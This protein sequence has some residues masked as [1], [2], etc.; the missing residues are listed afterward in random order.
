MR[1][2]TLAVA[3]LAGACATNANDHRRIEVDAR[4]MAEAYDAMVQVLVQR[5][6][7]LDPLASSAERHRAVTSWRMDNDPDRLIRSRATGAIVDQGNGTALVEVR[8]EREFSSKKT[9]LG[10]LDRES[11]AWV[12]RG[13]VPDT[14]LEAEALKAITTRLEGK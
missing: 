9:S 12:G 13:L 2:A 1:L 10:E 14:T 3:L 8:V 6:A 4:S 7:N 11:P 5:F